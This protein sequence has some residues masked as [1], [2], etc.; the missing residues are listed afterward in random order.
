[1]KNQ[2]K[3]KEILERIR[4]KE[5]GNNVAK[6]SVE[7]KAVE[8]MNTRSIT[9]GEE[10][11]IFSM[12]L[13][14]SLASLTTYSYQTTPENATEVGS[15]GAIIGL[16]PPNYY[17]AEFRMDAVKA[18]DKW[19]LSE[20]ELEECYLSF[21]PQNVSDG[22]CAFTIVNSAGDTLLTWNNSNGGEIE[23]PVEDVYDEGQEEICF[24]MMPMMGINGMVGFSI[25]NVVLKKDNT[26]FGKIVG[27]SITTPPEKM[28]YN[29]GET[30]DATGMVVTTTYE[31]GAM[32][33]VANYT[34]SNN[35]ALALEERVTISY[36]GLGVDSGIC[37]L[38]EQ[39][40]TYV[41]NGNN[42]QKMD[43]HIPN[44]L[45]TEQTVPVVITIHGG[46]WRGGNKEDYNYMTEYIT[47]TCNC[48][49]VNMNYR[50]TTG[51]PS[52]NGVTYVQ[53]LDDIQSVITYLS[54]HDSAYHID[55][56]KIALMGYSAGG[57]L[58]MLYA[59]KAGKGERL[60]GDK[61]QL[62]ISE[63]GPTDLTTVWGDLAVN[64]YA[65]LGDVSKSLDASPIYQI[66]NNVP[67]TILAYGNGVA[68]AYNHYNGLNGDSLI[69]YSQVDAIT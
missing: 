31:D 57:H 24:R 69:P 56:S 13:N 3:I 55:K 64:V 42:N 40:I 15:D 18:Q 60:Y 59:Y 25:D 66:S 5:N 10:E 16:M 36:N 23:L 65:M 32:R 37:V 61:I 29:V 1:M 6:V 41:N 63:A 20:Q 47:N 39:D 21:T 33:E 2:A 46:A 54:N 45:T 51:D 17:Y 7:E 49:H 50:L 8:N 9:Q 68:S 11:K 38:T 35:G 44:G 62:L 53:M 28:Q 34:I 22:Y 43:I 67:F 4:S 27:I 48:V 19:W 12:R 30:F 58:A 26:S 52:N 14:T